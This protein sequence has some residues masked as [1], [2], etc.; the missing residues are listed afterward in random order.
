MDGGDEPVANNKLNV[1]DSMPLGVV[2][3]EVG[4]VVDAAAMGAYM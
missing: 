3:F 1:A 4:V 2:I